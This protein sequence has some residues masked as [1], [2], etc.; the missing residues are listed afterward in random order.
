MA[1]KYKVFDV[2]A[3]GE[4]HDTGKVITCEAFRGG[5]RAPS[6][7]IVSLFAAFGFTQYPTYYYPSECGSGDIEISYNYGDLSGA[8]RPTW[9]LKKGI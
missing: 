7:C 1:H 8:R 4:R 6:S 2:D 9:F 3:S 5:D